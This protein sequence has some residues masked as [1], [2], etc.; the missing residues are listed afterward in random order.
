MAAIG[1]FVVAA[2]GQFGSDRGD[3]GLVADITDL[4]LMTR[5]GY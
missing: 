3:T 4:T 5:S 1:P 2:A